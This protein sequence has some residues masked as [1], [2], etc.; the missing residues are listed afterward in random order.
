[1]SDIITT[2]DAGV[3]QVVMNRPAAMNSLSPSMIEEM[4]RVLED[5]ALDASIG[6]I[7]IRGAGSRAF[8]AGGDVKA[9]GSAD[10]NNIE[11]NIINLRREMRLPELL[12]EI[13]KPT[14]AMVNGVAAGA[15]FSLALA[16][17]FR[18]VSQSARMTTAFAKVAYSGDFGLHY[19]LHR[20]V[21]T[22][23]ARELYFTA[24][25]LS[26]EDIDKLGL[27]TRIYADESLEAETMSFAKML[28]DGPRVAWQ[29]AKMSMKAAEE[30]SLSQA[31]DME[32][33]C[34]SRTGCTEE[35][36]EGVRAFVEK[37]P[38][39]FGGI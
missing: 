30:G 12:H 27:A 11:R 13:G 36:K 32:A 14:I 10:P 1:M 22:A 23:K 16:A 19:F 15:G 35:H 28:A 17:D 33:F 18:F 31:L 34:M 38:P 37:R 26:S 24:A 6:C 3:L 7:V 25:M 2:I 39:R 20:L 21:G 8:S 29:Y 5:A 4:Q 9:M